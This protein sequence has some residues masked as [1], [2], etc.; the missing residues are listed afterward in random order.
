[1]Y[2]FIF[3]VFSFVIFRETNNHATSFIC[4]LCDITPHSSKYMSLLLLLDTDMLEVA[5]KY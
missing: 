5:D 2:P 3:I 1:M 4:C